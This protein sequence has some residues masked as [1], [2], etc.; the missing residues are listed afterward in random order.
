MNFFDKLAL[1]RL[2]SIIL[3][4]ILNIAKLI[5]P[6]QKDKL[7]DIN[8]FPPIPKPL[9]KRKKLFPRDKNE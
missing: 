4:F 8:P 3:N 6:K 5:I 2:I 7:D 1:N 9:L